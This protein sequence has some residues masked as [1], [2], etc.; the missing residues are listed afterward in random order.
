MAPDLLHA[1]LVEPAS[2]EPISWQ[3]GSEGELVL[4]H[5]RRDC[6]PLVRFRSGDVI[7]LTGTDRAACGRTVPRFRVIG[8]SDDM[9]VVRGINAF[10]T[11]VAAVL[12]LFAEL[13]G[14]YRIVLPG[15]P[16]YDR[17][18]VEAELANGG[19]PQEALAEAVA[20]RLKRELGIGAAVS[21]LPYRSLPRS[22]GKTRR[23]VR[24]D[25]L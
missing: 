24:K 18:P 20:N 15:P 10:P 23:V 16:P 5:L 25:R 17:L 13:S 9:V 11:Q 6:Q 14:E 8:R 22:E 4:T 19:A 3:E 2:G 1:E 7:L 21:L 12:G